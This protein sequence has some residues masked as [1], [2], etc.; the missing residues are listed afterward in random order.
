MIYDLRFTIHAFLCGGRQGRRW[1]GLALVLLSTLNSQLS[2]C[3][4]FEGRIQATLNRDG[5]VETLLYTVGTNRLRIERGETDHPYPQN[6][7]NLDTGDITI[8]FPHN[9][10]FVRLKPAS[11]N[12]STGVPGAPGMPMPPGGLPPGIGPQPPPGNAST[13][14]PG[15]PPRAAIGPTNPP[16]MPPP[17]MMPQMPRMP[18]GVGPQPG[19]GAPTMP[20]MTIMPPMPMERPELKATTDTTNLLGYVCSRCELR[21]RGEVMEIWATDKMLPFQ[22]YLQNQP[23]R[24]GPRMLEEQWGEMLKAKKLFPLLVVLKFESGPE[25]MRFEVKTIQPLEIEDQDSSLF[26]PPPDYQ[27]IQPLPF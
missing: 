22:P 17:P 18:A 14:S 21:Q 3:I 6:L 1:A 23:H 20:A 27:E 8:L 25:R 24:F 7:V 9:R 11:E 16:G 2:T 10:S 19:S 5:P 15:L 12:V 26:Q 4:A 13:V